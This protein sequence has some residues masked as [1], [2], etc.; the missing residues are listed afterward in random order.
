MP[1][2]RA[3][4]VFPAKVAEGPF[5][6]PQCGARTARK[7][8]MKRHQGIHTGVRHQCPHTGCRFSSVQKTNLDTHL[9]LHDPTKRSACPE[10]E[11]RCK[12]PSS[13]IKHR[14]AKHGYIPKK[15]TLSERPKRPSKFLL[16]AVPSPEATPAPSDLTLMPSVGTATVAA[17]S[18][19]S[20]LSPTSTQRSSAAED[21][22]AT[23]PATTLCP[24]SNHDEHTIL[25]TLP[26]PFAE[27]SYPVGFQPDMPIFGR[28]WQAFDSEIPRLPQQ[29]QSHEPFAL[30]ANGVS[31]GTGFG[32]VTETEFGVGL[33]TSMETNVNRRFTSVLPVVPAL[34]VALVY[35]APFSNI[36][37]EDIILPSTT[38]G[39]VHVPNEMPEAGHAAHEYR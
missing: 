24:P 19:P 6:C 37:R 31:S 3:T 26:F 9:A 13:L 1:A 33:D 29:S 30:T 21:Y 38:Y 10:C 22:G 15:Y 27:Y 11:F 17:L 20:L 35:G 14:K 4:T 5:I 12:D 16:P 39:S 25:T 36:T 7:A 32:P 23:H 18:H 2:I 8:D 28:S 34:S